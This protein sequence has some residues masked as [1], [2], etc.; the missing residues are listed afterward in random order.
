MKCASAYVDTAYLV[1]T[2]S[3][4]NATCKKCTSAKIDTTSA[5]FSD[6]NYIDIHKDSI[7]NVIGD[8]SP[9]TY[10]KPEINELFE[11]LPE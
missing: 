2:T 7:T 11:Y 9:A 4:K 3:A 5:N 6:K 10:G 8:K 1:Q